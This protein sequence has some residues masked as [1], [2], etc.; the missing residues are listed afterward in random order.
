MN[1]RR[2]NAG[3]LT[4]AEVDLSAVRHN[5]KVFR[6]LASGARLM[7]VVKADAYGHGSVEVAKAALEAGAEWLGVARVEEG[8]ALRRAG[9]RSPILLLGL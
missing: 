6:S 7:A 1:T 2:H 8:L 5:V 4:W 9:I 3:S